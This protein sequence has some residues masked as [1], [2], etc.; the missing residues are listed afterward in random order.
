MTFKLMKNMNKFIVII[1]VLICG[2]NVNEK[3]KQQKIA[4]ESLL[5]NTNI[6]SLKKWSSKDLGFEDIDGV[7]LI[8]INKDTLKIISTAKFI[9]YPFGKLTEL[10]A[11]ISKY[12]SYL[13]SKVYDQP[14]TTTLFKISN[15]N[16]YFKFVNSPETGFFE[17]IH[18][19]ILDPKIKFD[20]GIHVGMTTDSLY[21]LFFTKNV[22]LDAIKKVKF[23]SAL[24]GINH[25]YDISQGKIERIVIDSD[26]QF[27]KD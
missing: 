11:L 25:I 14:D 6:D 16:N 5:I 10:N 18:A 15:K 13:M 12:P 23:T 21:G 4:L 27:S 20:N 9:Y 1:V 7:E 17:V 19:R 8:E 22:R 2:C 26:Y 3:N 24:D